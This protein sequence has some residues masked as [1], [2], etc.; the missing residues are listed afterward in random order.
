M[1][2]YR[3]M[4]EEGYNLNYELKKLIPRNRQSSVL[5]A[6]K[7]RNRALLRLLQSFKEEGEQEKEE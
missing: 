3:Y 2:Q 4:S 7:G 6:S 5:Q 1:L